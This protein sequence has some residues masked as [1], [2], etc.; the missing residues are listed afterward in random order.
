[1][2]FPPNGCGVIFKL[3]PAGKET[4]LYRFTGGPDGGDG[5][6][7]AA[8]LVR[9]SV[10][11][12][13]GTTVYGG[14]LL[15]SPCEQSEY[16][17]CG[18]VFKLSWNGKWKEDGLYTF[19]GST[20]G[21]GEFPSTALARDTNGNLYGVAAGGVYGVGMVFKL[22]ANG[23][24]T[25]LH[26]FTGSGGDGACPMAALIQEANGNL[27][28]T[29]SAGGAYG[30]GTVVLLDMSG[31]E[32][33][34]YSFTGGTDGGSPRAALNREASGNLYGTTYLGGDLNCN[35]P[36]GCGTVFEFFHKHRAL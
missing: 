14:D 28:G 29:T 18:T 26:N 30:Y 24:E 31:T 20:N 5:A 10:G 21:D 11:N 2:M 35:A 15:Y 25:I 34:L 22:R 7:P 12:L 33:V 32:T 36:Y 4:V 17:G 13:Y 1:M 23:D 9:D 8:R 19:G 3:S 16:F 6:Y 27:Y